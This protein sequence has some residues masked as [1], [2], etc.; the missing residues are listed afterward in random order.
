MNDQRD[1]D[2][3]LHEMEEPL[4]KLRNG[5]IERVDDEIDEADLIA[6]RHRKVIERGANADTTDE[7]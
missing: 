2:D 3:A 7:N 6:E 5:T 1:S 4:E